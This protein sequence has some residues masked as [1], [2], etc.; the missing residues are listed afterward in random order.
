MSGQTASNDLRNRDF[1]E[2]WATSLPLAERDLLNHAAMEYLQSDD[3]IR[4]VFVHDSSLHSERSGAW[5]RLTGHIRAHYDECRAHW[6]I[7][8]FPQPDLLAP[9]AV[10]MPRV[11]FQIADPKHA[12]H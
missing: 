9:K 4:I 7:H 11:I 6:M 3:T 10:I 12:T 5:D 1:F 2:Q 8:A